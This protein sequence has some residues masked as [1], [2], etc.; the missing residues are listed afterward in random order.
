MKNISRSIPASGIALTEQTLTTVKLLSHSR[1]IKNKRHLAFPSIHQK[2]AIH[3]SRWA[4]T[5]SEIDQDSWSATQRWL[6]DLDRDPTAAYP[7]AES[8]EPPTEL[9]IDDRPHDLDDATSPPEAQDADDSPQRSVT[10][11]P[12]PRFNK[13]VAVGF[14]AA[15][16]TAT[17]AVTTVL[18]GMR[19]EPHTASETTSPTTQISVLPASPD[20]AP[21]DAGGDAPIPYTASASCLPGSTAA[22]AVA[23]DNPS[24]AWVCVRG[25]VD[26][27]VLTL[28]LGRTMVITAVSITPGWVGADAS[29]T[30]Q[31]PAHRVVTRIQWIFNDDAS[32]VV[33]QQTGNVRGEAV[34]A[35]PHRGVLASKI[36]AIVL[37]TSRA[38]ADS[39]PATTTAAPDGLLDTILGPP[40]A[41]PSDTPSPLLPDTVDVQ[42][43]DPADNTFAVSTVKVLGHPP[44]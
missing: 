19:T 30:D 40:P 29:G 32:T 23:G 36:T 13:A 33:T 17:I 8:E 37:E 38:P 34:Q 28:D 22:Q 41:P 7:D 11:R 42:P 14:A 25:G 6:D 43:A 26:G 3:A 4:M 2:G 18:L 31:W 20:A 12:A 21:A 44:Q 27:Q 16:A 5:S 10:A 24:R 35:I 39:T 15:T 9:D 1:R